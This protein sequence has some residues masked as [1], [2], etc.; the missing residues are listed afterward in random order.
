MVSSI[1]DLC[2][3][4]WFNISAWLLAGFSSCTCSNLSSQTSTTFSFPGL[5]LPRKSDS[6]FLLL[7]P[8]IC[9]WL[10]R[11]LSLTPCPIHPQTLFILFD[12]FSPSPLVPSWS[13]CP[14]LQPTSALAPVSLFSPAPFGME[15]DALLFRPLH[16][17]PLSLRVKSKVLT[18]TYKIPCMITSPTRFPITYPLWPLWPLWSSLDPPLGTPLPR[19]LGPV[20]SSAGDILSPGIICRP[21]AFGF[22]QVC[23]SVTF[24]L[25]PSL[26]I[27][28]CLHLPLP[29]PSLALVIICYMPFYSLVFSCSPPPSHSFS[30]PLP[31]ESK[32]PEGRVFFFFHLFLAVS[33]MPRTGIFTGWMDEFWS[34]ALP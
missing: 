14:A 5:S 2:S 19:G 23:S 31:L 24:P 21:P 30:L 1:P 28:T 3:Q 13:E 26:K 29:L 16:W 4:C 25:W 9:C 22:L 15:L 32:P 18:V 10:P 34:G 11:M 17:A 33:A 8:E 7:R 12:E 6:I 27:D 20:L